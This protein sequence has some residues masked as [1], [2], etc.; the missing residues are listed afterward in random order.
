MCIYFYK[1]LYDNPKKTTTQ[2]HKHLSPDPCYYSDLLR[3]FQTKSLTS[4]SHLLISLPV[5]FH[6]LEEV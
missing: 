1:G 4:V 5:E 2:V 3:Y 6:S